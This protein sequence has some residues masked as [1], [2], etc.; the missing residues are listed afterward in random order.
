LPESHLQVEKGGSSLLHTE[1]DIVTE[2]SGKW[3]EAGGKCSELERSVQ[4]VLK[5]QISGSGAK[6]PEFLIENSWELCK[7]HIFQIFV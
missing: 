7:F 1:H 6:P 5:N 2:R 3:S 4:R